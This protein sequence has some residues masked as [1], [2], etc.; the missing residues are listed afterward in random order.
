MT[1]AVPE[2]WDW[3]RQ[4]AA[5]YAEV[6]AMEPEAGWHHW[7]AGRDRLF[8]THPQ[9]PLQGATAPLPFFP[10]DPAFRFVAPL[11]PAN[12]E[13]VPFDAGADGTIHMQPFATVT[14]GALGTLTLF[15]ILG[16]GGGVFLPFRD[17][18][19]GRETYGAGRYVLDT[20][21]GADLGQVGDAAVIDLNFA[22][23]PSCAYSPRYVCPLAP[24]SNRLAGAVRAG[25]RA[26][27]AA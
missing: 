15:W 11:T 20:I 4:V 19:S 25:E 24:L 27:S 2:L 17:A 21:K 22:Y 1:T 13:P 10:Y 26:P 6:R 16:Y 23:N 9:T 8:A 5:L 3:R 7:R 18:T 12:G 14:L